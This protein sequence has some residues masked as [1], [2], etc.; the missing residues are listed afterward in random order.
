M[1][2]WSTTTGLVLAAGDYSKVSQW[3]C[4]SLGYSIS[5][6]LHAYKKLLTVDLAHA[7]D[8]NAISVLVWALSAIAKSPL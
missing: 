5:L 3:L 1:G 8:K 6:F 2:L 7:E 4:P